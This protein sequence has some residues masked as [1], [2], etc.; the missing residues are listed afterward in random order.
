[1]NSSS[2]ST[3]GQ[4]T[5]KDRI[6]ENSADLSPE[7]LPPGMGDNSEVEVTRPAGLTTGSAGQSQPSVRHDIPPAPDPALDATPNTIAGETSTD[8]SAHSN[9]GAPS[10]P[11]QPIPPPKTKRAVDLTLAV[12]SGQNKLQAVECLAVQEIKGIGAM[13]T[14]DLNAKLEF[15]GLVY[16]RKFD[17]VYQIINGPLLDDPRIM[18]HASLIAFVPAYN[19][20]TFEVV[21]RPVKKSGPGVRMLAA[22]E[23]LQAHFPNYNLY[24][25]WDE[26]RFRHD[27]QWTMLTP[28]EQEVIRQVKWPTQEQ[29]ISALN[30]LAYDNLDDLAQANDNIR[31]M[32]RSQEVR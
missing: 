22:F 17:K 11:L 14:P 29:I 25:D 26:D 28:Q 6:P 15:S 20:S 13:F 1:M 21:L 9:L 19:W 3:N 27:V 24:V 2:V 30:P 23:K 18:K 16:K 7:S 31:L 4:P 8:A 12:L 10:N 32:L 5:R